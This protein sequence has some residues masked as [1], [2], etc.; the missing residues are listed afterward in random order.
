[1]ALISGSTHDRRPGRFAWM[2]G[3]GFLGTYDLVFVGGETRMSV[4]VRIT[5]V[6]KVNLGRLRGKDGKDDPSEEYNSPSS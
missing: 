5:V 4:R 1:M 6:L 2:P 3:P